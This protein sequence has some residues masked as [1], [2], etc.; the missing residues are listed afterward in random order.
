MR[1]VISEDDLWH[2][3]ADKCFHQDMMV[4]AIAL[5]Q[6]HGQ[7]QYTSTHVMIWPCHNTNDTQIHTLYTQ[8]K[9][10]IQILKYF[11]I[12]L[13][14]NSIFTIKNPQ[15]SSIKMSNISLNSNFH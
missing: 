9:L 11:L 15:S 1:V 14:S 2:Q 3:P 5:Q 8:L 13:K 7:I 12:Q 6:W 10:K 4:G